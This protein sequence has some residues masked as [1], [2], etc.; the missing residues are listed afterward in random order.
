[1]LVQDEFRLKAPAEIAWGVTTYAEIRLAEPRKAVM[2]K[3]GKE[4]I[5]RLAAPEN[6]AFTVESAERPKPEKTNPGC[7]RLVVR[8]PGAQ[9]ETRIAVLF[10]PAWPDGPAD[11]LRPLAPLDG[12]R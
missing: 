12:W 2:R 7:K 8:V 6:A 4:M 9:G 5:V 11:D 10:S 1:V 3:D